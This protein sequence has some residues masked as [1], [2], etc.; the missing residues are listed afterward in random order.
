MWNNPFFVAFSRKVALPLLR[1]TP[2][3]KT[4]HAATHIFKKFR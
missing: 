2:T 4:D 1:C 3:T